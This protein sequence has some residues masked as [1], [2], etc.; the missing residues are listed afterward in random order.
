[1]P[2]D[3]VLD[4]PRAYRRVQEDKNDDT[5]PDIVGYRDYGRTLDE[6]LQNLREHLK[7]PASYEASLPLGIDLPKRGFTLRP[8]LVPLIDDRLV[9]QALVVHHTNYE[10]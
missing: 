8:G 6:N 2:L 5:W 1:M 10:G 9:Y 3:E 7:R 4:L